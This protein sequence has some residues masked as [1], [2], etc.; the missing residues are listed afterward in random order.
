MKTIFGTDAV[1]AAG[2]ILSSEKGKWDEM[3]DAMGRQGSAA[4]VAAAK[5]KG[6]AGAWDALKSALE[7]GAITIGEKLA[8]AVERA[9]RFLGDFFSAL[10]ESKSAGEAFAAIGDAIGSALRTVGGKLQEAVN[11]I[12]W[13]AVGHAMFELLSAAIPPAF[14]GIAKVFAGVFTGIGEAIGQAIEGPLIDALQA[15]TANVSEAFA[16]VVSMIGDAVEAFDALDAA[17]PG[18]PLGELADSLREV[19]E[20]LHGVADRARNFKTEQEK[21]D[22]EIATGAG[23]LEDQ[24]ARLKDLVATLHGADGAVKVTSD[25]LA[26]MANALMRTQGEM[27]LADA[28]A[29]T[30]TAS[31]GR[32]PTKAETKALLHDEEA[33]SLLQQWIAKING[34]PATVET[35]AEMAKEG[36]QR[37]AEELQAAIARIERKTHTTS[38]GR[39]DQAIGTANRVRDA[40][41]SVPTS[42]HTTFTGSVDGSLAAAAAAA[43][44][45]GGHAL[46]RGVRDFEGGWALVGEEGPEMVLL[47]RGSDVYSHRDTQRMSGALARMRS[48]H[49]PEVTIDEPFDPSMSR[50]YVPAGDPFAMLMEGTLTMLSRGMRRVAGPRGAASAGD[51]GD[52]ASAPD[53][54]VHVTVEGSVIRERDLAMEIRNQLAGLSMFTPSLWAG[55]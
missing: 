20:G 3:A 12:D 47:P 40:V 35:K 10:S 50:G 17:L 16:G 46:A 34:T 48:S 41:N 49:G 29:L 44:G 53:V 11:A 30:L 8:P 51:T 23:I 54:V 37:N 19:E 32:I 14:S 13:G 24:N 42:H 7:T 55:R 9:V 22:E 26:Q 43:G 31:Y 38:T 6:L 5:S 28:A 4:E 21:L 27:K 33:R 25:G 18:H 39:G 2:A 15:V 36:A 52:V 45:L 1:R